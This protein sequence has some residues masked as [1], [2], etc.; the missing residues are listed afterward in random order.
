MLQTGKSRS[1]QREY[2][3]SESE[4]VSGIPRAY[5]YSLRA[6]C[7]VFSTLFSF[8]VESSCAYIG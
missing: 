7:V 3:D 8:R 4:A 1:S 6:A 5:A 2:C